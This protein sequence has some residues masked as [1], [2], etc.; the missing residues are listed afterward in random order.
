MLA[1]AQ[2]G[3][4]AEAV[5]KAILH[6]TLDPAHLEV[7]CSR[8]CDL[9]VLPCQVLWTQARRTEALSMEDRNI[10]EEVGM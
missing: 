10:V 4:H 6:L 3:L 2:S 8:I 1:H 9:W 7:V 5:S